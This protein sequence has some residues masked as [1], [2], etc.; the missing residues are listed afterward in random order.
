MQYNA[1]APRLKQATIVLR[2]QLM[3]ALYNGDLVPGKGILTI[4]WSMLASSQKTLAVHGQ[5]LRT[6]GRTSLRWFL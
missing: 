6:Y 4:I 1:I 3:R 2:L 5:G